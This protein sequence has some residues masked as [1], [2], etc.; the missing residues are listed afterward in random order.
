MKILMIGNPASVGWNLT[1]GLR[2]LGI[3]VIFVGNKN[4]FTSGKYDY[5]LSWKD[6]N[7]SKYGKNNFDIIHIHSPNIKK[8]NLITHYK[9]KK[10]YHWHGSDLRFFWKSFGVS[11]SISNYNLYST[12]DLAWWLRH[13][14]NNKKERFINPVDTE[15]FT[16]Y[17]LFKNRIL[18][19]Y[20]WERLM[21]RDISHND[22]PSFL[23]KCKTISCYPNYNLS[24]YLISVSALEGASCG[25][26]VEHH[27]Y[28]NRDWI[29]KNASIESQS[30]KL[31]EIYKKVLKNE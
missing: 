15:M 31:L 16:S 4:K 23:N 7:K 5:I 30:K 29:I 25:C 26:K 10:I 22:V 2:K 24:P 3:T 18:D 20:S 13:I 1:K 6:F 8:I 27:P 11:K 14:P 21:E 28:M 12:V 17:T 9:S 19:T